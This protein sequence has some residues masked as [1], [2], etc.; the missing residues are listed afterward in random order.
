MTKLLGKGALGII[1]AASLAACGSSA[2]DTQTPDVDQSQI[3]SSAYDNLKSTLDIALEADASVAYMYGK[4]RNAFNSADAS[5][6]QKILDLGATKI[7]EVVVKR[8]QSA[9]KDEA[10]SDPDTMQNL[11]GEM[12]IGLRAMK[13]MGQIKGET[14]YHS[15]LFIALVGALSEGYTA[16]MDL[17]N[18]LTVE[19]ILKDSKVLTVLL[20][21]QNQVAEMDSTTRMVFQGMQKDTADALFFTLKQNV[22][23]SDGISAEEMQSM[24]DAARLL[25]KLDPKLT[26]KYLQNI[27]VMGLEELPPKGGEEEPEEDTAVTSDNTDNA[28]EAEKPAEES[29]AETADAETADADQD[30]VAEQTPA[31]QK[32][33][34]EAK[35]SPAAE[36]APTAKEDKAATTAMKSNKTAKFRRV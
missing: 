35:E 17:T 31:P 27:M 14:R 12:Q 3:D 5:Y 26:E 10:F 13:E 36:A 23:S 16:R 9:L 1:M 7:S 2:D 33:A 21:N 22:D 29:K 11:I 6:Q 25:L 15:N 4:T 8:V 28:P 34:D 30:T 24:K 32:T 19:G 18:E 20:K